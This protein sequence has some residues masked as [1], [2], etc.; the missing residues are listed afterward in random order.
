MRKKFIYIA[1]IIIL[2]MALVIASCS[3][4]HSM[5][6]TFNQGSGKCYV[7]N[8]SS[9]SIAC[10]SGAFRFDGTVIIPDPCHHLTAHT[11]TTDASDIIVYI[12]AMAIPGM[13]TCVNC[14]GEISFNGTLELSG[15]CSKILSIVYNGTTIAEYRSK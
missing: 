4:D 12:D 5:N 13:D 1:I 6:L 2:P 7:I 15:A 8:Q 11:D 9:A 3:S 14:L 10:E